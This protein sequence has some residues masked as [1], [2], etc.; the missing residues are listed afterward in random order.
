MKTPT[1]Q[2]RGP[3]I[4]RG[5]A[6]ETKRL[7]GILKMTEKDEKL[8]TTGIHALHPYPGRMPP[9]WARRIIQD[10]P[11]DVSIIDPFC[12]SGTVIVEA[13][14]AGRFARG[15]DINPVAVRLARLRC[16][17]HA[18][19]ESIQEEA[20]R[21]ADGCKKRRSTPFSRFGKTEKDLP[22][23]VL[24]GLISLRDE[25]EKTSDEKVRE[26][27]L[28]A[29]SPLIDKFA[30][31]YKRPPPKVGKG[32]VPKAFLERVKR[33]IATYKEFSGCRWGEVEGADARRL[34]WKPGSVSAV[35]TSPPHPG[36]L[37][38]AQAQERRI[39]WLGPDD[40]LLR[41]AK[42]RE[43]GRRN[44]GVPWKTGFNDALRQIVRVT[45]VDSPIYLFLGDGVEA[46]NVVRCDE[47]I[48]RFLSK[49]P[50]E[51]VASVSHQ[52]PHFHKPTQHL[53]EQRPRME[54]FFLLKR[55][56]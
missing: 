34:P 7:L 48:D 17:P 8:A 42:R 39:D 54:H 40:T 27:L 36:V 23:H 46:G 28:F 50:L 43:I 3:A 51:L 14:K 45:R 22:K 10:L 12:G 29:F 25:V 33:W 15:C 20:E 49:L 30:G 37:D 41:A 13:R 18:N 35:I 55:T 6:H 21:C 5:P 47:A 44:G 1:R 53:F 11:S 52:R 38:S 24:A 2:T 31:S 9:I 19:L 16:I 4:K 26:L 56:D 32:A